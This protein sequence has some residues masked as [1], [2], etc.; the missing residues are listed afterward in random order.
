MSDGEFIKSRSERWGVSRP[1]ILCNNKSTT[2][3]AGY[4]VFA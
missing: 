3:R 2:P 4:L 1:K